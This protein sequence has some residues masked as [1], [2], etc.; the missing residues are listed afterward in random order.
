METTA[1]GSYTADETGYKACLKDCVAANPAI[2]DNIVDFNV[3]IETGAFDDFP[4]E[5]CFNNQWFNFAALTLDEFLTAGG[6]AEIP[7]FSAD[8]AAD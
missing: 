2:Q 6:V 4:I 1:A 3:C 5:M 8:L 7:E